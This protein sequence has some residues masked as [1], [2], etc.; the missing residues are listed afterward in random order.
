LVQVDEMGFVH[1]R[2]YFAGGDATNPYHTVVGAIGSGKRAALAIHEYLQGRWS[3]EKF[4]MVQ[5]GEKGTIS[6]KK[7][8]H[9]PEGEANPSVVSFK[10]M[11]TDYFEH[12]PRISIPKLSIQDRRGGFREIHL[13]L[14]GEEAQEE[15]SR[16]FNCG[17]CNGCDNCWTYCPDLAVKRKKDRYEIDYDYCKGCGICFEEC[18]RSAI[19]LEEEGR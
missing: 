15:A 9:P 1:T 12:Q 17:I 13:G 5:V 3:R 18:P 7:Y 4:R 8:F 19:L 2:G 11:N 14:K 6:L 16:C 10:E